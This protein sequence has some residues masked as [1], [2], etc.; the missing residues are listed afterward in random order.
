MLRTWVPG[1]MLTNASFCAAALPARHASAIIPPSARPAQRA[2]VGIPAPEEK[3]GWKAA[4]AQGASEPALQRILQLE[5]G[6]AAGAGGVLGCCPAA[7]QRLLQTHKELG[8]EI[9]PGREG[10]TLSPVLPDL[11]DVEAE[12]FP[13]LAGQRAGQGA[14]R[15]LA[16]AG[17]AA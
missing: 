16:A 14:D 2:S 5:P 1:P 9:S 6:T 15:Q 3:P 4:A 10:Q 8:G 13:R 12:L 11:E 17:A 7:L